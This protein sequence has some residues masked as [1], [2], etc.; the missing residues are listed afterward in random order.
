M[1]GLTAEMR[2]QLE[3]LTGQ[4]SWKVLEERAD[5][6]GIDKGALGAGFNQSKVKDLALGFV[7]DITM[8]TEAGADA[9]GVLRGMADEISS[10]LVEAAKTGAQLPKTLEPYIKRLGE[11]GL[12]IDE[13]GNA[14]DMGAFSFADFQDEALIAMKDL[15]TEIKDILAKAFPAAASAAARAI[16]QMGDAARGAFGG[17]RTPTFGNPDGTL[18]GWSMPDL[19]VATAGLSPA[20]HSPFTSGMAVD[21]STPMMTII[22]QTEGREIARTVMP[23]LGGETKRLGLFTR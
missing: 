23:Y 10:L 5:A 21:S 7:R 16:G 3:A 20:L 17:F 11:M 19:S 22:Q 12:L 2:K 14:I 18:P 1:T 8:F 6:L 13:N 9:D 15:L 4:P